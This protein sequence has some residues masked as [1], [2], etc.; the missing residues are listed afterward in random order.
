MADLQSIQVDRGEC[1][2]GSRGA[3]QQVLLETFRQSGG[4]FCGLSR[5]YKAY[6]SAHLYYFEAS[7]G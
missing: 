4:S 7:G 3:A 5:L 1:Q 6:Y 2:H